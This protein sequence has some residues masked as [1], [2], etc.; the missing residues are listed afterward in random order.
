MIRYFTA[1][2][3]ILLAAAGVGGAM[4][5]EPKANPDKPPA[6]NDTSSM[7]GDKAKNAESAP[8]ASGAKRPDTK[9]TVDVSPGVGAVEGAD[10]KPPLPGGDRK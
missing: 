10:G 7:A 4:A 2:L 5:Q 8:Q 3:A 9:D 6:T 1:A